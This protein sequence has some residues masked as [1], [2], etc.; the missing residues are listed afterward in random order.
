MEDKSVINFSGGVKKGDKVEALSAKTT[1]IARDVI[2]QLEKQDIPIFPDSFESV[3]EQLIADES[4]D[5]K[6]L[7]EQKADIALGCKDRLLNFESGVKS[8]IKNVKDILD[9]TKE[10]YQSVVFAHN[11]LKRKADEI[12]K[13]DNPIAF[14]SAIGLCFQEFDNLQSTMEA[15]IVEMKAAFEK[16]VVNIE[17]VNKNSIYDT[18]YGVYNKKYFLSLCE[19]EKKILDQIGCS[20]AFVAYSLSK[21]FLESLKDKDFVRVSLK[22]MSKILSENINNDDLL[23]Y[24]GGGKFVVLYK[25]VDSDK[26]LEKVKK[27]SHLAKETNLFFEGEQTSLEFCSGVYVVDDTQ[28]LLDEISYAISSCDG[29]FERMA[30]CEIYQKVSQTSQ[31]AEPSGEG[32]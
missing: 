16:I 10:I 15:Q 19:K 29:A 27:I 5:F 26:A 23:C 12:S 4:E 28:D 2:S 9:I 31:E 22:T 25:Y 20:Y 32:E 6:S 11:A 1:K 30:D 13:I 24:F 3:F 21:Q 14:K 7:V 8:G 18:Q 17:N